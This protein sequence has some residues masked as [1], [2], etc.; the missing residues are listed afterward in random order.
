M[1]SMSDRIKRLEARVQP[2]EQRTQLVSEDTRRA[3]EGIIAARHDG[4]ISH[5]EPLDAEGLTG[6]LIE[7]GVSRES[8]LG[9]VAFNAR[10]W[11]GGA[12]G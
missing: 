1:A 8:A 4:I 12:D 9:Y 7:R 11:P 5:G 6:Y 10:G 3:V 2:P